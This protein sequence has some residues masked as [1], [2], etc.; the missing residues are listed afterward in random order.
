[1]DK[2]RKTKDEKERRGR[3]GSLQHTL[4]STCEMYREYY[5]YKDS[6]G[7]TVHATHARLHR[8]GVDKIP[9][10]QRQRGVP[11]KQNSAHHARKRGNIIGVG[12]MVRLDLTQYPGHGGGF[13]EIAFIVM[14]ETR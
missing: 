7:P 3:E 2:R 9:W 12:I 4:D 10:H 14:L 11:I 6:T 1:M 8:E 5:G 13:V